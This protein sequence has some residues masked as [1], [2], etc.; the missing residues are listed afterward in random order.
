MKL[1]KVSMRDFIETLTD[2]E[3]KNV[4]GGSGTCQGSGYTCWCNNINLGSAPTENCCHVR[5][6][7][8]TFC[9]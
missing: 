3:L 8:C 5:C 7:Q 9:Q 1:K 6:R 4:R 2:N